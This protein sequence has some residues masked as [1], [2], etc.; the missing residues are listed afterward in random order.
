MRI[1]VE[2]TDEGWVVMEFT[3]VAKEP[4]YQHELPLHIKEK[5]DVLRLTDD[6]TEIPH[7]GYKVNKNVF[8]IEG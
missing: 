4:K 7:I 6:D 3:N 5:V 1:R 8:Y 2:E